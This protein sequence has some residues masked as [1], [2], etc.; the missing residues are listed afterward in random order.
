MLGGRHDYR[1]AGGLLDELRSAAAHLSSLSKSSTAGELPTKILCDL[2]Q[3]VSLH[4]GE[5]PDDSQALH[6]FPKKSACI[7]LGGW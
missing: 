1:A 7:G 2:M 3:D 6:T 5:R 4:D